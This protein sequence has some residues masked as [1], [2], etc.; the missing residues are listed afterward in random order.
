MPIFH[1]MLWIFPEFS[2]SGIHSGVVPE[3][4]LSLVYAVFFTISLLDVVNSNSL[5]IF[6]FSPWNFPT[7]SSYRTHYGKIQSIVWKM[8]MK[9]ENLYHFFGK[10]YLENWFLYYSDTGSDAIIFSCETFFL[11]RFSPF[12]AYFLI[13][14]FMKMLMKFEAA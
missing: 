1:T 14:C 6:C 5:L 3:R 12:Y 13:L 7:F 4:L 9:T 2:D 11:L 10:T 8:G